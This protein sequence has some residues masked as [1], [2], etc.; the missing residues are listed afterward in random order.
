MNTGTVINDKTNIPN[1]NGTPVTVTYEYGKLD[2]IYAKQIVQAGEKAIEPDVPSRQG[3][4][5]TD[6]YLDDTKYDFNADV[7]GDMTLTA[8][9]TANSYTITFDTDGGSAIDPITQGYGTTIKA[10]HSSH[11]NRLHLCRLG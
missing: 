11:Q 10:P 7:T 4:Q 1:P 9:W 2:G 6:W 5:F 3:Y 8:K